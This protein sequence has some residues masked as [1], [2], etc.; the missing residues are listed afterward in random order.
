MRKL[1]TKYLSIFVLSLIF[2]VNFTPQALAQFPFFN[3][4][5]SSVVDFP[6]TPEWDLNKARPCGKYWCS[7]VYL[8]GNSEIMEE[9]LTLALP[10]E[11]EKTSAEIAI[12]V[13]QRAK[14]VQNIFEGIFRN[15]I[16]SNSFEFSDERQSLSFWFLNNREKPRHPFTPIVEVGTENNQTV[17]FVPRQPDL[18]LSSQALVT[19][20]GIDAS[21]NASTIEELGEEW[22]L[23]VANSIS[24]ALWGA[25][26][27]H[28]QP[29][30][31]LQI[32]VI[33]GIIALIFIILVNKFKR[34][35]K[36]IAKI[37][38]QELQDI[39]DTLTVDPE[40]H[41]KDDEQ[42]QT[43][44]ET[45]TRNYT[46][47]LSG[48]ISSKTQPISKKIQTFR[49][50]LGR[51]FNQSISNGIQ[52]ISDGLQIPTQILPTVY[53]QTQNVIKQQLNLIQL[54]LRIFL[55]GQITAILISIGTIVITYRETRY[56]FNLFFSQ[57]ILVPII[58]ICIVLVDKIGDFWIDSI[59]NR[60]ARE[61]QEL[62]P[63]SNRPTLRVNTYSPAL[64]GA[65]TF[66]FTVIGISLTFAFTGLNP[67]VIAGA[68]A[69]AV[70]F[71]FL[72]RN[73]LED[74]LNGILILYTDRFAVGDVVEING[75]AGCVESM[76]LYATSLRNLDGQLIVIPN[77]HISTV[78]NMTK[79]WSRVN[80]TIEIAWDQDI[81]T[82][83]NLIQE[84]AEQ[85]YE[86]I[87]WHEKILE[88][89]DILGIEKVSHDGI[90]IRLLIK[91]LPAEQ[92]AVGRELRLRVKEAFDRSGISLGIPQREIW[93]R[94]S[95]QSNGFKVEK[96]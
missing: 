95:N 74:M 92:W 52:V 61:K 71:A 86:E 15:I 28:Q 24:D 79:N 50:L 76:N 7:D 38:R 49:R 89:A 69:A 17:V 37:L 42:T 40:A 63:N 43:D 8:F 56:L 59:L 18:G 54:L 80:F 60:W 31:R 96:Y 1:I 67:T 25:E 20:T 51:V 84:V 75:F 6:E 70:V 10:R 4:P 39:K 48:R 57:A 5:T 85:L 82:A 27:N 72:S 2:I 3:L 73:L 77:G 55:L 30:I 21:A 65:T 41:K 35:I 44:T 64:Q 11:S 62:F 33:V 45:K 22:R 53:Q 23:K 32:S 14:F 16:Q 78:V 36:K 88:P 47:P 29:L 58:W 34:F 13:E 90:M 68:G 91:T 94:D 12:D 81:K 19:V 46:Q 26:M 93:H 9:Q 83:T 87:E 66:I